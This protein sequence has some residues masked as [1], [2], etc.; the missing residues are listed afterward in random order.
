VRGLSL[1]GLD[2][3]SE[4]NASMFANMTEIHFLKLDGARIEG[5]FSQLSKKIRWM[6]WRSPFLTRLPSQ[7]HCLNLAVLDLSN[8]SSLTRLWPDGDVAQVFYTFL[9]YFPC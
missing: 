5:D 9:L 4:F 6:Q 1:V 3:Q 2:S 7:L 8:S